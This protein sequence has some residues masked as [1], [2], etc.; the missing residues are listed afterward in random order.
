[1]SM[2]NTILIRQAIINDEAFLWDILYEA[3]F[4]PPGEDAPPPSVLEDPAIARYLVD[5]GREHDHGWIAEDI[6]RNKPLGAAWLRLWDDEEHG[7]GFYDPA[8][9]ELTIA[10][11]P[12]ARGHGIGTQLMERLITAA[13]DAGYP[14]ISLS[15]SCQNPAFRLYERFGFRTVKEDEESALMV[16]EFED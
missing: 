2:T 11:L 13:R 5:W 8:Y 6:E 16:L 4:I 7:Y 15:V 3:I 14:G 9:P 1:M 10:L 12:E